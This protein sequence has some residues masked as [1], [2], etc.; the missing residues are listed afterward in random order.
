MWADGRED[1]HDE[2]ALPGE[3]RSRGRRRRDPVIV[4]V[5]VLLVKVA[6]HDRRGGL[7]HVGVVLHVG[8][9]MLQLVSGQT[10]SDRRPE[11][12]AHE[13]SDCGPLAAR[14]IHGAIVEEARSSVKEAPCHQEHDAELAVSH[15]FKLM[16]ACVRCPTTFASTRFPGFGLATDCP[17]WEQMLD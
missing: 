5:R 1:G 17:D 14:L 9:V 6:M 13:T 3:A 4:I 8:P 10:R 15:S 11:S 12:P 2:L 7:S 16:E